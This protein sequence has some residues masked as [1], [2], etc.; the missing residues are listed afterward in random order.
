VPNAG[1]GLRR[2][3]YRVHEWELDY[4]EYVSKLKEKKHVIIGGDLNVA[5]NEIDV[6]NPKK[7]NI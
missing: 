1:D 6:A 5:H 3:N 4:R 2:L 7:R